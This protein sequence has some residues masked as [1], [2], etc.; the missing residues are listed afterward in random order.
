MH[1]TLEGKVALVI[2]G[3]RGSGAGIVRRLA[4][5]GATVAFTFSASMDRARALVDEVS[6]SGGKALALQ[7]DR[8]D[9]EA[10]K[11]VVAQIFSWLGRLDI[12]VNLGTGSEISSLVAYLNGPDSRFIAESLVT[13]TDGGMTAGGA[14]SPGHTPSLSRDGM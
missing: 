4:G 9:A 11:R 13:T 8:A 12:L 5:D 6:A 1:K 3:S 2:G 14:A 10:V 7:A